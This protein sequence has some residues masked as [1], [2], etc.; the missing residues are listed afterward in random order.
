MTNSKVHID[1]WYGDKKEEADEIT[2]AFYDLDCE[3]RGNIYKDGKGNGDF[4]VKDSLLI[5]ELFPQIVFN[6]NQ[7]NTDPEFDDQLDR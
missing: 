6:W 7:D 1:M 3:Y 5:E 2:V 4:A